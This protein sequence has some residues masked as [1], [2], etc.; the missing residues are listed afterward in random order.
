[1]FAHRLFPEAENAITTEELKK[2][3]GALSAIKKAQ[4][5]S[6]CAFGRNRERLSGER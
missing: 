4:S 5:S 2:L 6:L 3:P 1:L